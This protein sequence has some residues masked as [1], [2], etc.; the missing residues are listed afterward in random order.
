M[1]ADSSSPAHPQ[2]DRLNGWKEIAAFLGKGVRTV[3]RW[4]K[5]YGLPIRRLGR[6]GGEIIF[7]NRTELSDW[8]RDHSRLVAG[9][10]TGDRAEP[11]PV[12]RRSPWLGWVAIAA[13]GAALFAVGWWWSALRTGPVAGWV[14]SEGRLHL[15]DARGRELASPSFEFLFH[16]GSYA[17]AENH[18]DRRSMLRDIDGDGRLELLFLA[19]SPHPAPGEGFYLFNSDGTLRWSV[20]LPPE[21]SVSFAGREYAGPWHP[22][23]MAEAR[24]S[25]GDAVFY[26]TFIHGSRSASILQT[27]DRRGRVLAKYWQN[28]YIETVVATEWR[29]RPTVLVGGTNDETYRGSLAI[30]QD[31]APSGSAPPYNAAYVCH[32]CPDG[33][34]KWFLLFPDGEIAKLQPG[35]GTAVHGSAWVSRTW[36]EGTSSLEVD[37]GEGPRNFENTFNAIVMYRLGS[38]LS[39]ISADPTS[40]YEVMHR[41]LEGAGQLD[42]AFDRSTDS[43]QWSPVHFWDGT[44]RELTPPRPSK[45]LSR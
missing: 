8:L 30:F 24:S 16:D 45:P 29:G 22:Y 32:G 39:L 33:Y 12:V 34:P 31:G 6:D 35:G 43:R 36:A 17:E 2:P 40:G 44:W 11:M 7:A 42:H 41:E 28:G 4:E 26:L 18:L 3:Q 14:V 19:V 15:R 13:V 21:V 9:R 5:E 38:D 37:V 10:E 23:R 27:V 25:G 1:G 20:R